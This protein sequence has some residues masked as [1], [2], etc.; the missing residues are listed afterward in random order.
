MSFTRFHDDPARIQKSLEEIKSQEQYVFN[1]PGVGGGPFLP[2]L[3]DHHVRLQKWGGNV[4]QNSINLES[5]LKGYTRNL[6]RDDTIKNNYQLHSVIAPKVYYPSNQ[7]TFTSESLTTHPA[8]Q[9]RDLSQM[10]PDYLFLDPQE[11]VCFQF[12]H[13][14][15][16]NILEKDYYNLKTYKKI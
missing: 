5:D 12:E 16:T 8:W 4:H 11:N 3:S 6:N 9:Y 2:Y 14:M 10:R 15:D 13:N 1:T 7:T